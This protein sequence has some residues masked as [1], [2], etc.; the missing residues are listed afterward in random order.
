M[1]AL[2]TSNPSEL[3]TEPGVELGID[4]SW[5]NDVD[6]LHRYTTGTR[7]VAEAI[8]R[9]LITPRGALIDDPNYGIGIRSLLHRAMTRTQIL[10]LQ[11]QIE[12]EIQKEEE[13]VAS[14]TCTITQTGPYEFKVDV[15]GECAAGPFLLVVGS[16]QAGERILEAA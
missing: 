14:V 5:V 2:I 8:Y 4:L 7:L 10:A 3:L 6:P 9:R 11:G 16:D 15:R 13:R 12:K 1:S